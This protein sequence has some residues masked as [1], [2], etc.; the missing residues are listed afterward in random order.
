MLGRIDIAFPAAVFQA[1]LG[2]IAGYDNA[3]CVEKAF[4]LNLK[5]KSSGKYKGQLKIT[6]RG[7]SLSR[8]YQYMAA[9]RMIMNDKVTN[10]WYQAKLRRDG[11]VKKKAVIAVMRKLVRALWY[12]ARGEEFDSSKLFNVKILKVEAAP[13]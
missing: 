3:S 11:N 1:Q 8:K 12:V 13:C 6:K 9:L 5:V 10:A 7:P 4:G 2:S